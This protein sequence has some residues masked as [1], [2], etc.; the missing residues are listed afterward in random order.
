MELAGFCIH[1]MALFFERKELQTVEGV[2][3]ELQT[4]EQ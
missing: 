3:Q 1:H 4:L 2:G